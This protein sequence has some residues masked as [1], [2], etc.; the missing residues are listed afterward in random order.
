V[1][2]N[3]AQEKNVA[4]TPFSKTLINEDNYNNN[5]KEET[6]ERRY[7]FENEL[8]R[9][10]ANGQLHLETRF[11]S[12]FS[13][14]IFEKRTSNPLQNAK[15]Y[16]I[17]TNTLLRKG[18]EQGGVHPVYL[19]QVSTEYALKIEAL[20]SP[21]QVSDL[22]HEMFCS[23]C[24]LVR[25]HK[26]RQFSPVVQKAILHIDADLSCNLSTKSLALQQGV[27]LGYLSAVFKKETGHTVSDYVCSRRMDYAEYLLKSTNLLIQT[28]ALHCGIM[29]VYYFSKLFK[30][31]KGQ[32]PSAYRR[33][34]L[35]QN[36]SQSK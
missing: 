36:K 22:M 17:I 12:A 8:I 26:L 2:S 16:S 27:S 14:D 25:K 5:I 13:N 3:F 11:A 23:Y 18:A 4:E 9:A 31:H 7:A 30:K 24:R 20:S 28:I 1:I 29:D 32:T 15:N 6:I 19:N 33:A 10:V 35:N 34:W 21:S